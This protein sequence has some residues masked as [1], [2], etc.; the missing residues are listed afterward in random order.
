MET[1]TSAATNHGGHEPR[2]LRTSAAANLGGYEQH[3]KRS[4]LRVL[5]CERRGWRMCRLLRRL[6][7]ALAPRNDGA[8]ECGSIPHGSISVPRIANPKPFCA[9]LQIRRCL[10]WA[11][12]PA[13]L[14]LVE[15]VQSDCKSETIVRWI[16]LLHSSQY[17]SS[18]APAILCVTSN[19]IVCNSALRL[20]VNFATLRETSPHSHSQPLPKINLANPKISP[21]PLRTRNQSMFTT[22]H[23]HHHHLT[24]PV[25][26]DAIG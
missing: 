5:P 24:K 14:D 15:R 1:R 26:W 21:L 22:I 10:L 20:R 4:N 7:F 8:I 13:M 23:M 12:A 16:T 25:S 3:V 9:G 19:H 17:R 2:R 6:R 18:A 11:V